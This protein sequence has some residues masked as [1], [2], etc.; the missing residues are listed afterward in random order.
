MKILNTFGLLSLFM[1]D[2]KQE[3]CGIQSRQILASQCVK[4]Q[5]EWDKFRRDVLW[6]LKLHQDMPPDGP[7]SS[8]TCRSLNAFCPPSTFID[9]Y[10][11]GQPQSQTSPQSHLHP[12]IMSW[13]SVVQSGFSGLL[14]W[15]FFSQTPLTDWE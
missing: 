8:M 2:C 3:A 15:V 4:D 10:T 9:G 12:A 13:Q 1:I 5:P 11:E 7:P 6:Q 14:S